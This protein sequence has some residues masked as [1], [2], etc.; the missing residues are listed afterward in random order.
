MISKLKS[1]AGFTLIEML[2]VL[3]ILGMIS[4]VIFQ[5]SFKYT[6]KQETDLFIN[7]LLLDLQSIQSH[8]IETKKTTYVSFEENHYRVYHQP[9]DPFIKR[10]FPDGITFNKY[11][12][13]KIITF[14]SVGDILRFGKLIFYTPHGT[15]EL[16][17]YIEK[18]RMKFVE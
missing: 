9:T 6:E 15:K 5:L 3:F 10:D 17:I 12:N 18:G 1:S 2:L 11:S 14:T 8:A 7:Q 4:S 16:M 13:L